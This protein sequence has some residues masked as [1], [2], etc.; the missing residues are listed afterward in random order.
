MRPN[1]A[2]LLKHTRSV[3]TFETM[4]LRLISRLREE[5]GFTLV[6]QLVCLMGLVVIVSAIAGMTEVT[7]RMAPRDN[8]RGHAVRE[9][10]VGVDRMTRE[11]RHAYSFPQA[12]TSSRIVANVLI[13][14]RN[15]TV[16]YDCGVAHPAGGGLTRC[17]RSEAGSSQIVVDRVI[18]STQVGARQL[19]TL[20]QRDG[21]NY[22][23]RARLEVPAAGDRKSGLGG[24]EHRVVLEDG[25]YFRNVHASRP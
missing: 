3:P 11:L 20:T 24:Q 25:I 21:L 14:G 8:E 6:E 1:T 7:E 22:Y 23:V 16:T 18:N 10:Q 17:V 15:Y 5:R 13:R 9:A 19:F 12:I 2:P 4:A